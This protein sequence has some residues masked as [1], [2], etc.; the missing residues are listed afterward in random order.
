MFEF[1]LVA[2][3]KTD[4]RVVTCLVNRV[5]CEEG[6]DWIRDNF[7][8]D[9]ERLWKWAALEEGTEHQYTSWTRIKQLADSYKNGLHIYR[10]PG[11][12][13]RKAETRKAIAL[14]RLL[15]KDGLPDALI[16]ARDLDKKPEEHRMAMIQA[17]EEARQRFTGSPQIILATPNRV[18]EVWMLNGF[19]C[20]NESEESRLK[21]LRQEVGFDPCR[22]GHQL[23]SDAAK[24]SIRRLITN[25]DGFADK[26]RM[27]KCWKTDLK[28]LRERGEDSFLADF[29]DEVSLYLL[30][31]L[32][33][34]P[35]TRD[36]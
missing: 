4:E 28:T 11:D 30:P 10:R 29:L 33:D 35:G 36:F 21:S 24:E 26:A 6:D 19:V 32:T 3:G 18:I 20:D 2:E 31:V 34:R 25:S 1:V 5:L 15:R 16:L 12:G 13:D 7:E 22:N 8:D 23:S 9:P 14:C 27:E 17:R